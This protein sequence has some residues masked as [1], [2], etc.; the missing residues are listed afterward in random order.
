MNT[1]FGASRIGVND[2]L[3]YVGHPV[4]GQ[5]AT[6][7]VVYSTVTTYGTTATEI[8][9]ALINPGYSMYLKEI[10]VG[11]T[12][13]FTGLNGSFVGSTIYYWRMRPECNVPSRGFPIAFTG[14]YVNLSGTYQAAVGTLTTHDD[15]FSGFV[16]VG[17]VPYAPV[18]ISL[19]AVGIQAGIANGKVKN[20]SYVRLVGNP[21]PG[22]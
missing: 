20:S 18:R 6:D 22:C 12:K 5:V 2:P 16:D 9:S 1:K 15:T 21:I 11:L 14:N 4:T 19:M 13:R 10:E 7:G 8:F 17:S 3:E